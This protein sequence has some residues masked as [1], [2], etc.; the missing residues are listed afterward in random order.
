MDFDRDTYLVHLVFCF[1]VRRIAYRKYPCKP[2]VVE[3][4][5]IKFTQHQL[6]L[7]EATKC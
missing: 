3:F 1:K 5:T 4:L 2:P 7:K 6:L